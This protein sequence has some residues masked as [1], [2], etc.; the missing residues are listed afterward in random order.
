LVIVRLLGGLGNQM[1]QYA[2]GRAVADRLGVPLLLDISAFQRYDLRRFELHEW[3][4][5]ADVANSFA[6]WR[7]G[8][9]P[10]L[11]PPFQRFLHKV[12]VLRQ[13]SV[14]KEKSFAYDPAICNVAAPIV[15]DGYWQSERYFHH[16]ADRLRRD[17]VLARSVNDENHGMSLQ[18]QHAGVRAVSLH[19]RRGDYVSDAKT[20]QYHGVCS[21]EYYAAAAEHVA[22]RVPDPIFFVFSDDLEWVSENLKLR[23]TVRLVNVN[24]PGHGAYDMAL[25]MA[26]RHHV[27]ANSSFSW[28]GAWLNPHADKIVIAPK[29]WFKDAPHD[30]TDLVPEGWVRL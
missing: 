24:G 20:A 23:H 8:T 9:L 13:P 7:A 2:T 6:L 29:R 17:F 19:I 3:A 21:L 28:W 22:L 10:N 16:I 12:R 25:M 27:I 11:F 18:I 15:L 1:F 5:Q 30:T 26:C 14:F 4:V